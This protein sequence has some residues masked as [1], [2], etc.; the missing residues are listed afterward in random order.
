MPK[1]IFTAYIMH[2]NILPKSENIYMIPEYR[3]VRLG[4]GAYGPHICIYIYQFKGLWTKL[5]LYIYIYTHL[6]IGAQS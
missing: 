3:Y 4:M 2:D 5:S 1:M 6:N